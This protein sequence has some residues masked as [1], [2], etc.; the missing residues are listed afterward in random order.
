MTGFNHGM[1]GA[2]IALSVKQPALAIPLSFASH[3]ATDFVPHFGFKLKDVLGR[4]FNLF[5]IADFV[6]SLGLMAGLGL[7]FPEQRT[8]IWACMIAAAIPDIVWWFYRSSVRNWPKGLDRFTAWHFNSNHHVHHF[9]YDAAWF[10]A[11][12]AIVLIIKL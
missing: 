1:T 11:M 3:Y 4:K 10:A 9:Y 12:W 5:T 2:V 7:M 6:F 8:L